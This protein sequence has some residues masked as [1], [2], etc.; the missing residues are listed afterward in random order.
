MFFLT[1]LIISVII[2]CIIG[3]LLF[4]F[5]KKYE[6]NKNSDY[7]TIFIDTNIL[8]TFINDKNKKVTK[9]MNIISYN[10]YTGDIGGFLAYSPYWINIEDKN[11][12]EIID[13]N[14]NIIINKQH[15]KD[16]F[17]VIGNKNN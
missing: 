9:I 15:R 3:I 5:I 8:V 10:E 12:I 16:Y 1:M 11:I 17:L 14:S 7:N 2:L 4:S 13:L 6:L